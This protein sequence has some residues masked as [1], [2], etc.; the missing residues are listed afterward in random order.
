[1]DRTQ[2]Y[3]LTKPEPLR[4]GTEKSLALYIRFFSDFCANLR[5]ITGSISRLF[6]HVFSITQYMYHKM[7]LPLLLVPPVLLVEL[8]RCPG[9]ALVCSTTS[10]TSIT[11][12]PL[13]LLVEVSSTCTSTNT[14]LTLV[15]YHYCSIILIPIVLA[16]SGRNGN[17]SCSSTTSSTST[18]TNK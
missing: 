5:K 13:A 18:S 11:L 3:T 15:L 16:S 14:V 8:L 10:T 7:V 17:S 2:G 12:V 4:T 1:M 6:C 9:Q